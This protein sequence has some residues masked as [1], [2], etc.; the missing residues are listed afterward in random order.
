MI[1]L[2][3]SCCHSSLLAHL[4]VAHREQNVH[5]AEKKASFLVFTINRKSDSHPDVVSKVPHNVPNDSVSHRRTIDVAAF[6]QHP[7]HLDD[8][9][10]GGSP[11]IVRTFQS[12]ADRTSFQL[13]L[14]G[15]P[16][17]VAIKDGGWKSR[18]LVYF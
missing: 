16:W 3:E 17:E 8:S 10:S 5:L 11:G 12:D 15:G 14:S 4:D 13:E 1:F 9:V 7:F 6:L 2:P 18:T